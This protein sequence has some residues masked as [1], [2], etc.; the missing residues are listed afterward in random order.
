MADVR[1]LACP[2]QAV[3]EAEDV[4]VGRNHVRSVLMLGIG[5]TYFWPAQVMQPVEMQSGS[6]YSC[7]WY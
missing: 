6:V 1:W 3:K 4:I 5:H 2:V 7:A